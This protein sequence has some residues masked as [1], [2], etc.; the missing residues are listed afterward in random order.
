MS[1]AVLVS[2]Q[3]AAPICGSVL[4]SENVIDPL[5][6]IA[7]VP[8]DKSAQLLGAVDASSAFP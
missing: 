2:L 7:G 5:S 3:I 4:H 6:G 8:D 1:T